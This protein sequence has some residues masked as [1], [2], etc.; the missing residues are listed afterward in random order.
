M[1]VTDFRHL[2]RR[3][4]NVLWVVARTPGGATYKGLM[5]ALGLT[6]MSSTRQAVRAAKAEGLVQVEERGR[7]PGKKSVV[8]LTPVGREALELA[9]LLREAQQ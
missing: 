1:R 8:R 5:V 9:G 4:L 6:A 2:P 3:A 7:G